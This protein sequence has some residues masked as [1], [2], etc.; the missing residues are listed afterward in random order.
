M[1]HITN[2]KTT[3]LNRT[4]LPGDLIFW[5][6]PLHEGPVPASNRIEEVTAARIPFLA[7]MSGRPE[8][9][10]RD[11]LTGRDQA[12]REHTW[13]SEVVFWFDHDLHDQLQLIQALDFF[14]REKLEG[15]KLWLINPEAYLGELTPEDLEKLFPT[16]VP[17]TAAQLDLAARAW[18]AFTSPEPHALLDF[19]RSADLPHLGAAFARLCDHYPSPQGLNRTERLILE[20]AANGE[21]ADRAALFSAYQSMDLPKFM[22]DSVFYRYLDGLAPLVDANLSL[23]ALGRDVLAGKAD[24]IAMHGVDRWIGGVHLSGRGPVWR[25]NGSAFVQA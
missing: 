6:D 2:G 15:K 23:T 25:W 21:F 7:G 14:S 19:T 3:E 17:V 1:L 10:V 4:Y 8:A 11:E 22:G 18:R 24:H 20:L 13:H 5:A 12:L 9:E 16:R